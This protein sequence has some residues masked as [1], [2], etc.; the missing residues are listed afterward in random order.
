MKVILPPVDVRA[1]QSG[2]SA[3]VEVSWSPPPAQG[4]FEITGYRIFYSS[5][6]DNVSISSM[7]T[8]PVSIRVNGSY[9]GQTI[10]IR[11]EYDQLHSELVNTTVGKL[12]YH[13]YFSITE[14]FVCSIRR[15]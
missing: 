15:H 10:S 11:S 13:L 9:D 7:L 1:T 2:P 14:Y 12:C 5:G 6:L 8:A 3:P 4:G